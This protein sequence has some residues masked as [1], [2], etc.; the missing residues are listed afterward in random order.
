MERILKDLPALFCSLVPVGNFPGV[1][2]ANSL[3]SWKFAFPKFRPRLPP[4]LTSPISS[5]ALVT[6]RSS[7]ASRLCALAAKKG[8][9]ILGCIKH[10]ITSQ[11]KDVIILLYSVLVWPHLEYCVQFWAPQ[12]K[13][14]I[15]VLECIQRKATKLVK[16]LE[17][18]SYEEWLRTLG[19]SNLEKRRLR[20]NLIALCSFL[21][22]G[23]GEGGADLFSLGSSDRACGNSSKLHQGRFRLDIRK[24]FFTEREVKHWNRLPREVVNA[25][26]LERPMFQFVPFAPCPVMGNTETSLSL[27]SL[28]PPFRYILFNI[29]IKDIYSGIECTF[30]KFADD[31]KLIGAVGSL[32]GRD[33]IQRGLESLEE[34]DH[35]NLRKFNKT[36]CKVLH[37][38]LGNPQ[39]QHKLGDE[40]IE[41]SPAEKDWGIVLNTR[42]DMKQQCVL[43]VQKAKSRETPPGLLHQA[44]ESSAQDMDLLEQVQ[45]R[46]AKIIRGVEHLSYED[47]LRKLWL[48]RLEKRR[49]QGD[50]IVAFQY[51]KIYKKDGESLYTWACSDRT[52]G[53]GFKLKENRFR[54][55]IS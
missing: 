30:S 47:R 22:R 34:W 48:L 10:S 6:I 1:L 25:P 41:S 17:G 8:N 36:K 28:H 12:F 54:L 38:G 20:G 16:G 53:N 15:Q 9:R 21:R 35:L 50:L 13:K 4:I 43:A 19:L 55:D 52:R 27:S 42:L 51:I 5:L 40:W 33:A 3:K 31:T 32:E 49:L 24:H 18:M 44:L 39:Y 23:H 37:L 45:R 11:P 7:I 14:D 29:F 2:L 26:S 46:A